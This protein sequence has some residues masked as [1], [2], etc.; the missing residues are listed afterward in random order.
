VVACVV[1]LVVLTVVPVVFAVEAVPAV[2]LVPEVF[3]VPVE[4]V[5]DDAALVQAVRATV[6][7][8][9]A[10]TSTMVVARASGVRHL[11]VAFAADRGVT[12]F[13]LGDVEKDL[14]GGGLARTVR[15]QEAGD[16]PGSDSE[17]EVVEDDL[18]AVAF[19]DVGELKCVHGILDRWRCSRVEQ[20]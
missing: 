11:A 17:R 8:N 20:N 15:A 14:H 18:V 12:A 10:A 2:D 9:D 19:R 16:L 1:P 6:P 4:M 5:A 13:G 7:A 3:V